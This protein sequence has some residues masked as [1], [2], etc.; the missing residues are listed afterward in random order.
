MLRFA[1]LSLL[2]VLGS[3]CRREA[4]APREPDRVQRS[5]RPSLVFTEADAGRPVR[6]PVGRQFGI[7]LGDNAS[8]G[9]VWRVAQ[10]PAI[11]RDDG[12]LYDGDG[13][14][15]PGAPTS[16]TFRFTAMRSGRGTLLMALAYRDEPSRV[17]SF[18]VVAQ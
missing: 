2:V 12:F 8:I 4:D 13:D 9:Y 7:S 6:V 11:L 14:A 15:A 5:A 18:E 3:A 1:A 10:V 17:L 16:K